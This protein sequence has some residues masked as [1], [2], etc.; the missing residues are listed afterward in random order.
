MGGRLEGKVAIITGGTS[1]IGLRTVEF[2]A[3]EGALVL[4]AARREKEGR[5]LADN[6]GDKVEF[7][8]R[9]LLRKP[10]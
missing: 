5:E 7:Q 1:G 10:M 4:V 9:M 2:F 3:K 6:L 8:K